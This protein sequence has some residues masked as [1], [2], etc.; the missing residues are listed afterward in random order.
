MLVTWNSDASGNAPMATHSAVRAGDWFDPGTWSNGQVPA[1]GA[2]VH[3]PAGVSVSYEGSSDASLFMV[4]V[5]GSLSMTATDGAATKMVV[6]TMITSPTSFLH[7]DADGP[8]DGTVDIVFQEGAPAAH[9]SHFTDSSPGDGVIGRSDWDPGQLSLGLVASGEVKIAGQEVEGNLQ[10]ADGPMAGESHLTFDA[11]LEGI[12]TWQPG[13]T[14]VIGGT[15]YNGR[16]ADGHLQTEDEVRT[17]T[18]VQEINGQVIVT[19]DQPLDH[20]HRGPAHPDTG[21]EMTGYVANM[22]RNVNFSSA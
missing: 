16:D 12:D 9:Q 4:R 1:D 11:A 5:D 20:D 8:T 21:A 2:L 6:D 18:N 19:L 15:A 14:L 7:V 17:I 22:S 13:Q 10:L 3:I